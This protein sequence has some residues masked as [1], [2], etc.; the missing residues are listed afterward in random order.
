MG[1]RRKKGRKEGNEK[2]LEVAG[3][4]GSRGSR[5]TEQFGKERP[6]KVLLTGKRQFNGD[7]RQV[8]GPSNEHQVELLAIIFAGMIG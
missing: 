6:P 4:R 7:H 1:R 2:E 3:E 8:S 5:C